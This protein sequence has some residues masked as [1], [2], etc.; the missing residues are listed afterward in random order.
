MTTIGR[1]LRL[2]L[3]A[4]PLWAACSSKTQL[5][6]AS[7]TAGAGGAGGAGAADAGGTTPTCA[8]GGAGGGAS[9]PPPPAC[10]SDPAGYANPFQD[11]GQPLEDRI[12]NLLSL[13]TVDEKQSLLAQNQ[14]AIPRLGL[15]GFTTFT[16]GIHGIGWSDSGTGSLL[17]MTGTQFPQAFGLAEAWDP[18]VMKTVGATTGYEARVY[19]ARGVTDFGRGPGIVVRAPL[20]DLG[21][22]PRWGR[23]EESYGEDPHLTGELVKGYLAGLHGTDPNYLM[24]ASMLKHWLA[25]NNET[26]RESSSSNID[27]RNLREYYTAPFSVAV[28]AGHADGLMTAYN[29]VNGTPAAVSPLL[30]SL[31]IGEWGFDGLISTDASGPGMLVTA[32]HYYPTIEQSVAELIKDGTGV[33]V[34]NVTVPVMTAYTQGLYTDADLDA[35]LRP[36]LRVRFRLGDLD[37]A[38]CV[39]YKQ[40]A[41]TETPWATDEFKARALDV[42]R[43]TI[44]LLKNQG[45]TLPLDRTAIGSVAVIGPRADSVIRDWYGGTPPYT[46]TPRQGLATKLGAGVTVR[47]AADDTG[48]AAAAAAAMSDVAI[49]FVGNNPTCGTPPP[50][51][52]TCPT[53]YDGREAVDRQLIGLE[54]TQ[55]ALV[56]S[57]FAANPRTVVVLVSGYPMGI[58]WINDNV[59]AIVHVTNSS[60]ELGTAVA[61]VL[62]GDYNPAGRTTMT[63]YASEADIPTDITDYDIRKGTTYW[64]F[65]GTPLYPFGHGLGYT[66][67]AYANLTLSAASVSLALAATPC[68]PVQ[69]GADV[70]NTGA[71]TS[72]EVVQL[73]VAYPG[74]ALARPRQQLR[75][76]QR[77][78]IAAGET[79]HLTFALTAADLSYWDADNGKPA[80]EDGKAVEV[81]VGASSADIRLRGTLNVGP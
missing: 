6:D 5:A 44:V 33:L 80:I 29:Q 25:N 22:D 56:Q 55:L 63:W 17:Y 81:Q 4:A 19:N 37:P 72:D 2:V 47:Y 43:K 18:E 21:R 50:S 49:V 64:Y 77:V 35:A 40:I 66:T 20:V 58:G 46:V 3:V 51:W 12:T 27:D 14:P 71:R 67:F 38:S 41:S 54:P 65:T 62:F 36:V 79:K 10:P 31:V 75:G 11:P 48:G 45:A 42:T 23:T 60:Q 39:P 74:S 68:G 16:E 24:A 69:V 61:D 78:S 59:P 7:G 32:Q 73:Y 70:T 1:L 76:F 8:L 57:V 53:P 28:Q 30:K 26:N 34:Q 15:P 52:G 13:L 9:V